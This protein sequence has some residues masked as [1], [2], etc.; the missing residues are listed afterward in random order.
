MSV[1]LLLNTGRTDIFQ[2]EINFYLHYT[3]S[4][5]FVHLHL[6]KV[7]WIKDNPINP[8]AMVKII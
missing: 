1:F 8:M 5:F 4:N 2:M 6:V 7:E 3:E